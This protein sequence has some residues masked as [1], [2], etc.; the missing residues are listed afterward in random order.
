MAKHRITR[1]TFLKAGVAATVGGTAIGVGRHVYLARP[2][3]DVQKLG[4]YQDDLAGALHSSLRRLG[5]TEAFAGKRILLKP[6][7]VETAPVEAPIN[8]NPAV[9]V[10]AAEV[11]R[12]LDARQVFVAEG[13]GHRRDTELVLDQSGLGDA[14]DA[15]ELDFVDLNLQQVVARPNGGGQTTLD[16]LYLPETLM[17][18]DV[19]VSLAKLKTHHW[20]G[21][22]LSM[23]NLFGVMPGIVYGWPKNR[24]HRAGIHESVVDIVATVQPHLA[25]V[26][27]IV[28]ME[29]DGPIM[30]TPLSAGVLV[31]GTNFPAV[32]ATCCRI[33]KIDPTRVRYLKLAAKRRMGPL[34]ER[35]IDQTGAT[36]T[37]VCQD[38][39]VLD[40]LA[41]IK[42]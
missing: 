39:H 32:D 40:H 37:E 6:N 5:L 12:S 17:E 33:M 35:A 23:K 20:A 16:T 25:I 7:L 11:F 36:P 30:G 41:D 10:A 15:A 18:A 29:G 31:V 9:V 27:G 4:S 26:D 28:G 22:T 8:T 2:K 19:I 13:A 38:F 3:V 14:L 21:A 34:G 24:L 1:R 42:A